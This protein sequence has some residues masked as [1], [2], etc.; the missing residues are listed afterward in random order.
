MNAQ[1]NSDVAANNVGNINTSNHP[2]YNLFSNEVMNVTTEDH[3]Q[4]RCESGDHNEAVM[5][6]LKNSSHSS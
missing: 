4:L 5:S 3:R 6:A 1:M 2:I